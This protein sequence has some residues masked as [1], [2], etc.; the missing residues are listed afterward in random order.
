MITFTP[1]TLQDRGIITSF[2][3]PHS[4]QDSDLSFSNLYCWHFKNNSSYA[5]TDNCL[6]IRFQTETGKT[7]YRM[8]IGTGN[9]I[10][11][12]RTL[13]K[14]A[15]QEGHPLLIQGIYGE[16]H[17]TLETVF[18]SAFHYTAYRD[19]FDYIYLR[20]D[21]SGLKGKN[22][23]PKRNHIN[24]FKKAYDYRYLNLT[25]E[26]IPKCLELERRWCK[27]HD[28]TSQTSLQNERQALTHALQH[29]EEL[30]L[31]GGAIAINEE[32]VA[33]TLGSPV[34]HNTFDVQFEKA[35]THIDGA[36]N[37]INQEF[38]SHLPEQYLYINRE[39][40][41]GIPGLRKAKLSYHPAFLL[42]KYIATKQ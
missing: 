7:L 32:I 18:P 24:K 20:S 28:C 27:E 2:T 1:I 30:G 37:I 22:Y 38:V 23:Q 31:L 26:I 3:Y 9:I 21:L 40:D 42:E 10:S 39:E 5:I 14:Q 33:F 6:I 8:P 25:P 11:I 15:A 35:D 36:Y 19:Y 34:N 16:I 41:L 12:I 17:K 4:S 13:E 29:Y